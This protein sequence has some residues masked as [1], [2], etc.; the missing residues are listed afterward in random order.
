[1]V[2]GNGNLHVGIDGILCAGTEQHHLHKKIKNEEK[3][4]ASQIGYGAMGE[5]NLVTLKWNFMK[6]VYSKLM[7]S[8]MR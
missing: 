3:G 4:G 1:M 8:Q 5:L 2:E 7:R 6:L